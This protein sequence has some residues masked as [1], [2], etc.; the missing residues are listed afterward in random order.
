MKNAIR[1]IAAGAVLAAG[2]P[3]SAQAQTISISATVASQCN[4]TNASVTF[5]ALNL[6]VDNTS[7]GQTFALTCNR[8]ATPFVSVSDGNNGTGGQ[9]RLRLLATTDYINY[10]IRVPTITGSGAG[11]TVACPTLATGAEWNATTNRLDATNLFTAAG[12]P[13]NIPVCVLIPAPSFDLPAGNFT[14]SVTVSVAFS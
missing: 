6:G 5:V 7:I 8:G 11:A 14:D 1:L 9:K 4:L 2:I 3:L 12:G 13:R 10:N